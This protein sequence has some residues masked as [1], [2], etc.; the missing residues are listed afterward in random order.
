MLPE[1]LS[2]NLTSLNF[3]EDR[4]ALIIEMVIG[5]DGSLQDSDIYRVLVRNQARFAYNGVAAWLEGNGMVP[6]A[7]AAV[8]GL[9]ENLRLQD[10]AAQRLKAF[11]HVHGALSLETIEAK[12]VFDGDEIRKL[13]VE[14]KNRAKDHY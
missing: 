11:R 7:I 8:H 12:P 3:N 2:T 14:K 1:K 9:E 4:S 13:E 10:R 5:D 6:E